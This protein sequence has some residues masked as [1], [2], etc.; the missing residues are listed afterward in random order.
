MGKKVDKEGLGWTTGGVEQ[1]DGAGRP[2]LWSPVTGKG[3]TRPHV[4][5]R[6]GAWTASCRRRE[7]RDGACGAGC[8]ARLPPECR[9]AS[10]A[11]ESVISGRRRAARKVTGGGDNG[12]E[13]EIRWRRVPGGE[14]SDRNETRSLKK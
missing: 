8:S 7:A 2:W 13:E 3:S 6:A 12:D 9:S 10:C 14:E 11:S 4:Q 1:Q 5:P